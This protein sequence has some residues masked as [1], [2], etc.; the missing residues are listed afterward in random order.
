MF[1]VLSRKALNS[2]VITTER[3]RESALTHLNTL[4]LKYSI[5]S[6]ELLADHHMPQLIYSINK[7][8]LCSDSLSWL[9]TYNLLCH[10]V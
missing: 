9:D 3:T 2:I 7:P 1:Y 8:T 4:Q 10:H 5:Q 6:I